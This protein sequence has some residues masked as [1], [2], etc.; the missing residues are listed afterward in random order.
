MRKNK[1][2]AFIKGNEFFNGF[3]IPDPDSDYF[4]VS[5]G[6]GFTV[7]DEYKNTMPDDK[8]IIMEYTGLKDDND[9]EIYEGDKLQG[10]IRDIPFYEVF[11][12]NGSFRLRYSLGDDYID[13][14]YLDKGIEK[15]SN[16]G[17]IKII[18]NMHS[19]KNK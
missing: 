2:R 18:G 14:G 15:L 11:Y 8:Y 16:Y 5:N 1:F 6:D 9:V 12:E 17:K 19:K 10:F 4:M 13:W 3:M 7:Y